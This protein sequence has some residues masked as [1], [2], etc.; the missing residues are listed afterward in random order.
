MKRLLTKAE[1]R[2]RRLETKVAGLKQQVREL[3]A[4]D[5]HERNLAAENKELTT[6]I[7]D[8]KGEIKELV[9]AN[10]GHV[11]KTETLRIENVRLKAGAEVQSRSRTFALA[12]L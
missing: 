9:R 3:Q 11:E 1:Q 8:L 12:D 5:K 4:R 6:E 2:I 7:A 10:R